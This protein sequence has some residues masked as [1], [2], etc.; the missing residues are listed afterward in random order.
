VIGRGSVIGGNVWLTHSVP[1]C[2]KVQI[3]PPRLQLQRDGA[4][5]EQSEQLVWDI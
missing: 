5:E 1:P 4:C 3:E 2:S